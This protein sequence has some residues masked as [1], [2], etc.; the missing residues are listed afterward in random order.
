MAEKS[1][2]TRK[3]LCCEHEAEI[4]TQPYCRAHWAEVIRRSYQRRKADQRPAYLKRLARKRQYMREVRGSR[5]WGEGLVPR[6]WSARQRRAR[7]LARPVGPVTP[8]RIEQM[9]RRICGR[10]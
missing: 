7:L 2:T 3:C 5:D 9:I 1:S 6:E 8:E 10:D 4:P